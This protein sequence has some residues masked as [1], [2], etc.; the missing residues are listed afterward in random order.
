MAD[1]SSERKGFSLRR[2]SARKHEAARADKTAPPPHAASLHEATVD[3]TP[4]GV[5][6]VDASRVDAP[7]VAGMPTVMADSRAA[8]DP[9]GTAPDPSDPALPELPSLDAL[10]IDSDYRGF[11]QP[12]VD[13][14]LKR[15]ALK[16]LFSDPRFNVMD[17]LDVYID[18]YSK[19]DPIE[20]ELVRKLAQ[21]RYIFNPP[22]TRVNARGFIEDVPDAETPLAAADADRP[23]VAE[24]DVATVTGAASDAAADRASASVS[25]APESTETVKPRT[26]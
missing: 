13:E 18:D 1:D 9:S 20:P 23:D 8:P 16:K 2:W 12:G 10:T 5:A 25:A 19:P 4:V 3:H 11:M 21:A 26:T 15:G 22:A 14:T 6:P 24:N 17:G 7:P